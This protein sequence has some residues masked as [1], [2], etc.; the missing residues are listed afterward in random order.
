MNTY[1]V[2]EATLSEL[3]D[4]LIKEKYPGEPVEAHADIK[5]DLMAK[6][7][8]K[9]L[10]SLIGSLTPEQGGELEKLLDENT[11]D[12]AVFQ[13]FFKEHNINLEEAFKKAILDFKADFMKGGQNEWRP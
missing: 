2:D 12:P 9:I 5:Q 4:A 1:L 7:D 11:D 3:A 6:I 10:K 8:Y 13:E